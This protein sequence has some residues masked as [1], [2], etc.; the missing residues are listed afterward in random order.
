[1]SSLRCSI[2]VLADEMLSVRLGFLLQR[3]VQTERSMA[4]R[5]GLWRSQA[6]QEVFGLWCVENGPAAV[7]ELFRGVVL[8]WPM[9]EETLAKPQTRLPQDIRRDSTAS[10]HFQFDSLPAFRPPSILLGKRASNGSVQPVPERRF[11]LRP[12]TFRALLWRRRPSERCSV[13]RFTPRGLQRTGYLR[14]E[15]HLGLYAGQDD[16]AAVPAAWRWEKS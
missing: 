8:R 10:R 3:Q 15:W 2:P 1:M 16:T 4:T 6:H 11:Q 13:L 9:S 14:S 5:G 7:R 12:P